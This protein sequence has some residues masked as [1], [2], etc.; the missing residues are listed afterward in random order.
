MPPAW[1]TRQE[2]FHI[3]RVQRSLHITSIIFRGLHK[4]WNPLILSHTWN[5]LMYC[6]PKGITL[7]ATSNSLW[8]WLI[9]I[10]RPR[11]TSFMVVSMDSTWAGDKSAFKWRSESHTIPRK[12]D[13][14]LE[15]TLDAITL[16]VYKQTGLLSTQTLS[17]LKIYCLDYAFRFVTWL[18][19]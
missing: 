13:S 9:A 12:V 3:E 19:R 1:E 2:T 11:M 7:A 8:C 5:G 18:H 4:G 6:C 14:T 16:T 17:L 15:S 10:S